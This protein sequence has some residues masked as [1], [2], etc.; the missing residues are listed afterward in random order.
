MMWD[1]TVAE[2][3]VLGLMVI[4]LGAI[5]IGLRQRTVLRDLPPLAPMDFSHELTLCTGCGHRHQRRWM[6]WHGEAYRCIVCC[7]DKP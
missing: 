4:V 2:L 3:G 5:A 7:G 6:D 1:A